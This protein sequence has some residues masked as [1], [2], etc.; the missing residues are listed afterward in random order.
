[1]IL[2]VIDLGLLVHAP[3]FTTDCADLHGLMRVSAWLQT[4]HRLMNGRRSR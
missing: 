2:I 1:M 3:F 4:G